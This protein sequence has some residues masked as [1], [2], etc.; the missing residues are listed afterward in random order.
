[1]TIKILDDIFYIHAIDDGAAA[2]LNGEMDRRIAHI[3]A[4]S[5][6]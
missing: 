3:F 2:G 6:S 5:D 1:V 4:T